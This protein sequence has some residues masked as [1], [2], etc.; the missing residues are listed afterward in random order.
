APPSTDLLGEDADTIYGTGV[1]ALTTSSLTDAAFQLRGNLL[2][3]ALCGVSEIYVPGLS[4]CPDGGMEATLLMVRGQ[5]SGFN[6]TTTGNHHSL[7]AQDTWSINKYVTI[8]AGLRWEQQQMIGS[9]EQYTFTD[10]WAPRV[11]ISV[12]PWGNRKTKVYANFARY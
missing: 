11:G 9:L 3:G 4:G 5:F 12:D 1:G 8:N 6:F 10:N 2:G 7:F